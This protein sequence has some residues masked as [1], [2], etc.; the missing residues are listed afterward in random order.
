MSVTDNAITL[1]SRLSRSPD[2]IAQEV[3][4]EIV[5]LD[6][7]SEQYFGLNPVG[8]RIWNLL[9]QCDDLA[10]V[11]ARLC[12]EYNADPAQIQTD[13][14]ALAKSLVDAELADLA[15]DD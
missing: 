8:A 2:V 13:L 11:H 12:S 7:A 10:E 5:L 15:E 9:P 6:L 4:G 1:Q 14:L 3:S